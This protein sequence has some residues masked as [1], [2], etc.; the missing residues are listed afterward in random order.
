MY[1]DLRSLIILADP[2]E[3]RFNDKLKIIDEKK[4]ENYSK[5][6]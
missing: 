3:E 4:K 5:N 1:G 2:P 6:L